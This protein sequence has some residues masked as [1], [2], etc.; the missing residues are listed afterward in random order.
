V[1]EAGD[2]PLVLINHWPLLREPT[3]ILTH[4]V[5]AQW[6]GT[7]LTA[8]WHVSLDV[9]AVVYGHLHVPRTTFHDGVRFEE[10]SIGYPHVWRRFGLRTDLARLILPGV[11]T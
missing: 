1:T 6:C 7:E 3:R 5:F 11:P 2:Y 10:V 9:T 4:Q 8:D